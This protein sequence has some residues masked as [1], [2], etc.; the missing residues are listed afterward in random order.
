MDRW[1][2]NAPALVL[3]K[4]LSIWFLVNNHCEPILWT[5]DNSELA[6][7]LACL[8]RSSNEQPKLGVV[9]KFQ[10]REVASQGTQRTR[11]RRNKRVAQ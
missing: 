1:L 2:N 7:Y 3:V 8:D 5:E 10:R 6:W 11:L 4:D 9:K